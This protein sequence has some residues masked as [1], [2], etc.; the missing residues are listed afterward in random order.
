MRNYLITS[1][2]G[3]FLSTGSAPAQKCDGLC[4]TWELVSTKWEDADGNSGVSTTADLPSMKV[5]NLTHFSLTRMNK[6]GSFAGHSGSYTLGNGAYTE[7]IQSAS[8]PYLR[9]QSFTFESKLVGD[10]WHIS[11]SVGDLKLEEVWRRV[12]TKREGN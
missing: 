7:H 1:L 10:T 8:N 12:G 11:G 6:D 4:G 3:L 5:L 2:L 9:G